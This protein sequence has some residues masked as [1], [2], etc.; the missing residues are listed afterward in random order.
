VVEA[1]QMGRKEEVKLYLIIRATEV[2]E[3]KI[4][5][6]RIVALCH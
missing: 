2:N 3:K 5:A 6:G 1:R 4:F